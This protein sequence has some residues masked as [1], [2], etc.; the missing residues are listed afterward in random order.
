MV[1][2][3]NPS[4][5]RLWTAENSKQY[6]TSARLKLNQLSE[7]ELRV[8]DY[9]EHGVTESQFPHLAKL[10]KT[11]EGTVQD[12]LQR[13][14]PLIT[15]TSAF[16][17]ELSDFDVER[18]FGEIMRLYLMEHA[19]PAAALKRRS[20]AKIFISVLNRTGLTI[21]RGLAASGI[22]AAFTTDQKQVQHAD[23]LDL[24]YPVHFLGKPRA[25]SAKSLVSQT[26]VELHSRVSTSFDRA[27][28]AILLHSDATPPS[29][30]AGWL[31][32]DIPHL[33]IL[34]TEQGVTVSH[35]VLPGISP[36]L[37]CLE[38][39]RMTQDAQWSKI[40]P[41]L[42]HLERD[43]SDS[44]LSLFAASIALNQALNLVDGYEFLS[45]QLITKMDRDG[46]V[47]QSAVPT[48]N[49][50]CRLAR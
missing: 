3:I 12:L 39:E 23:T 14:G 47:F 20:E 32:R 37:A 21:L 17:A 43:L 4:L 2:Q 50:G 11:S 22:G 27:E 10:T 15:K 48:T 6:G 18:Q 41:Q 16:V 13:L 25:Q 40:A 35:L 7:A 45:Q 8:L 1:R 24:G 34:F 36:C 46:N 33:S 9:L 31:S 42:T 26:R 44:S 28:L 29:S 19:D 38:I 30:Y 5:A 49:C